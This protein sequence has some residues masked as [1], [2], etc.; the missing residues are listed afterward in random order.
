MRYLAIDYWELS[1]KKGPLIGT[2]RTAEVFAW[3]D[4]RVLKLFMDWCPHSWIAR[5]EGFSRVVYESGLPVPA[6][7]GIIEVDG[8]RG[9]IFERVEGRS[10]LE[11]MG[12]KPNEAPHYAEILAELHTTIHSHEIPDLPS[13]RDMI[14]RNIHQA[15]T[16]SDEERTRA[17]HVLAQRNDGTSLCHYDFHPENVIMSPRGPV[18]IDWMS[19]CQGDPHADITRTLLMSQ[20]FLFA[21]PPD[22]HAALQ[23]FIDRYLARYREIR[24]ISLTELKAW[25]LPIVIARLNDNIPHEREWLSSV[26]KEE[27]DYNS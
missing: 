15:K 13:L 20:G 21:I 2:G 9:I 17:L 26:L 16:L 10:M 7:E 18:I 3:G 27:L 4:D 24:E 8:R 23:S 6:V 1:M 11:E 12:A 5:E 25:R 19:A 22:W 14:E